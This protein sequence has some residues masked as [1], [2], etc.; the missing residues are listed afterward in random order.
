MVDYVQKP[1]DPDRL[2]L[3]I[4]RARLRI[5]RARPIPSP[6][7]FLERLAL[8]SRGEVR[9]LSFTDISHALVDGTLVSVWT[10]AE[11]IVTELTL[12]EL[13]RRLPE[14]LFL[15]VHRRALLNLSHVERLKPLP[16]G[17]Y[18]AI[19]RGGQEVP[20]S[21]QAARGIRKSLGIA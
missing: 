20:V 17:G 19:T 1:I 6:P 7:A 16:T 9:L 13:E 12:S 15:R 3:A 18:L 21:R 8:S 10:N 2:A 14:G 11:A 5:D 4:D